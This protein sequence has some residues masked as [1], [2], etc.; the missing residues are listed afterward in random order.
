MQMTMY[1]LTIIYGT[2][3]VELNIKC[4]TILYYVSTVRTIIFMLDIL[5]TYFTLE[6][7]CIL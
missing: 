2:T 5:K 3:D 7:Y 4:I 1:I 6:R